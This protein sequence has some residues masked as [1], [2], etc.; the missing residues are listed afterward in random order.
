MAFFHSL[1]IYIFIKL[2]F[3][4][5]PTYFLKLYFDHVSSAPD[6]FQKLPDYLPTRLS[7]LFS[8][9]FKQPPPP[10]KNTPQKWE[11]EQSNETTKK[12]KSCIFSHFSFPLL[13]DSSSM[14][15]GFLMCSF[16]WTVK[17]DWV[18]LFD[19]FSYKLLDNTIVDFMANTDPG[20]YSSLPP[21]CLAQGLGCSRCH[22][23]VKL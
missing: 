15:H 21:Q 17:L 12:K 6:S 5:S 13:E 1:F 14:V 2:T 10:K 11:L 23:W 22:S 20:S 8:L 9:S 4:Y 16:H 18:L 7:D 19:T 3:I